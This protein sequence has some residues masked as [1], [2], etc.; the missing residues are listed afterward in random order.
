MAVV[1]NVMRELMFPGR[2]LPEVGVVFWSFL[3]LALILAPALQGHN[4]ARILIPACTSVA[5]GLIVWWV[6]RNRARP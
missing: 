2:S 5:L 6:R 4:L 1:R 3:I